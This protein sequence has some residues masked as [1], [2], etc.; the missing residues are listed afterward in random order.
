[1]Q[2]FIVEKDKSLKFNSAFFCKS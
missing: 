2:S 1:L